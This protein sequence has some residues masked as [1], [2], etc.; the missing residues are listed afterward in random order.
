MESFG[1]S[2]TGILSSVV[3]DFLE[4]CGSSDNVLAPK[5]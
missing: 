2:Y 3:A 1:E 5:I 4:S